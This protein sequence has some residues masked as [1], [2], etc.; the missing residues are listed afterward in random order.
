MLKHNIAITL[1]TQ[2]PDKNGL[3]PVRIRTII[4]RVVTYYPTGIRVTEDQF[5]KG[6]IIKHPKKVSYNME[7]R[8]MVADLE[9]KLMKESYLGEEV[10]KSK[11]TA[12]LTFG[13]YAKK[14]IE[15]WKSTQTKVTT[16]HKTSYLNKF[17]AFNPDVKLKDVDRVLLAAYE[18][19]CRNIGNI[20]N[21]VWSATKFVKTI[22][23][24]AVE[25]GLLPKSPLKGFRGTRYAD[26]L[27]EV[28]TPA[29]IQKM[30]EFADNHISLEKL[31]N[32]ASWFILGCYSGLRYAD[33][34]NFKGIENDRILLKTQKTGAVVSIYAT[35]Q[36]KRAWAR[37][38]AP[39]YSNQKCNEYIQSVCAILGIEKKISFHNSRHSFCVN[40]LRNGGDVYLL[41]KIVGHS[42]IKTTE[43]Y[44][45]IANPTLDQEMIKVF[46]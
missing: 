30:E 26:P 38:N 13:D 16:D 3:Y 2:R 12:S 20:N 4:K 1:N 5:L 21:T 40:F 29:E 6:E 37:I 43:I 10:V 46:G 28:L 44:S 17:L 23:N 45:Q 35:D 22:I 8:K 34:V 19:Y 31:R 14:K 33:M 41:S 25:D 11:R 9:D 39:I 36:I 7:L 18:S 24:A 42:T 27:R 32:V 15:F